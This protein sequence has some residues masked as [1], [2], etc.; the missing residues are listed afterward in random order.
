MLSWTR[1]GRG[2]DRRKDHG[3]FIGHGCDRRKDHGPF[4]G[5]CCVR[6]KHHR[7]L[8]GRGCDHRKDHGQFI[9]RGC[10]HHKDHEIVSGFDTFVIR[11]RSRSVSQSEGRLS[12]E[13]S[14]NM[15]DI[16]LHCY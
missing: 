5:H 9:G 4:I 7:P 13:H 1:C 15:L 2:C 11:K 8:I 12:Q 3:P 6:R 14:H 16:L 10:D